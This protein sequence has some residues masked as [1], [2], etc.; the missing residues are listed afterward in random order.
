MPPP[1]APENPV[2][3]TIETASI[4][5][6]EVYA[7]WE[8]Y[9]GGYWVAKLPPESDG[10]PKEMRRTYSWAPNKDGV[11]IKGVD[12]KGGKIT[13]PMSGL[14]VWNANEHRFHFQ[15]TFTTGLISQSSLVREGD[16]FV[17]DITQT[18]KDGTVYKGK[19][20]MKLI[21]PNLGSCQ[22][23]E[24]RFGE[25]IQVLDLQMERQSVSNIVP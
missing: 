22:F 8:P 18:A 10:L 9:I 3:P 12:L 7:D 23:F 6:P 2:P 15:G 11:I 20:R 5:T 25:W 16:S 13:T 19:S 4:P 1:S 24:L 17:G 14:T 21:N